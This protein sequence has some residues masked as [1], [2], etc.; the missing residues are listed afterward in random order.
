VKFDC[1]VVLIADRLV[2][3]EHL[4]FS[5]TDYEMVERQY[6]DEV[7]A[8][9]SRIARFHTVFDS[10]EAFIE[11]IANHR[12]DIVL[13]LWAGERSWSRKALVPAICEAYG[14]AFVGAD[15]Y[16]QIIAA[17]KDLSKSFARRS[18]LRT[19]RGIIVTERALPPQIDD[20]TWPLVVKPNL[21]GASIGISGDSLVYDRFAATRMIE[22]LWD[23]FRQPVL[24]EEF[25]S[26]REVSVVMMG[27]RNSVAARVVELILTDRDISTTVWSY[28]PKHSGDYLWRRVNDFPAVARDAAKALFLSLPKVEVMRIDGRLQGDEFTVIELSPDSHL[29]T[30]GAAAAAYMAD[31]GTYDDFVAALLENALLGHRHERTSS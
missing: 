2:D 26:G 6:F 17:D 25:L 7:N 16:T 4:A 8:T 9:L 1:N 27:T 15:A 23:T 31:G 3:E 14:V 11:G 18:G 19:A 13:S 28:E 12:N 30:A 24:V 10:P 21:E 29:G 22:Q 20:L 5:R